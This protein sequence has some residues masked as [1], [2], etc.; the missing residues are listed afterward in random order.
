MEI[1]VSNCVVCAIAATLDGRLLFAGSSDGSLSVWDTSPSQGRRLQHVR[2]AHDDWIRCLAV[3][4]IG[5]GKEVLVS[6]SRDNTIRI[7][8]L[9]SPPRSARFAGA[10]TSASASTSASAPVTILKL[11]SILRGHTDWVRCLVPMEER[12]ASRRDRGRDSFHGNTNLRESEEEEGE[13]EGSSFLI[14]SA[15]DDCTIREWDLGEVARELRADKIILSKAAEKGQSCC[16]PSPVRV[17][18]ECQ[19]GFNVGDCPRSLLISP[20]GASFY[21]GIMDSTVRK[22]VRETG[23]VVQIL[24]GHTG[25]VTCMAYSPSHISS[26]SPQIYSQQQQDQLTSCLLYTGSDDHTIRQWCVE[27]GRCLRIFEGHSDWVRGLK[28]TTK[29]DVLYSGS[30]DC[31]LRVWETGTD[32][33]KSKDVCTS[34]SIASGI[35]RENAPILASDIT[36]AVRGRPLLQTS[37]STTSTALHANNMEARECVVR[38]S[39]SIS[40]H[41]EAVWDLEII[42]N[43]ILVS[44]SADG[45]VKYWCLGLPGIWKQDTH[46][47]YPK[48]FKEKVRLL[49]LIH[50]RCCMSEI[51]YLSQELLYK[52]IG[53]YATMEKRST[54]EGTEGHLLLQKR[55]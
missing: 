3:S 16:Q 6:G 31:T 10:P 27:S 12:L 29:G 24:K 23:Q 44:S 21:V 50:N 4:R 55:M 7:W 33:E 8:R 9:V 42:N 11:V 39:L 53:V 40:G 25:L 48:A 15:S 2:N 18:E 36:A 32:T 41:K 54:Q 49:L 20:D 45:R 19:R 37:T 28:V 46:Y 34:S 26:P 1:D 13:E 22:V 43:N 35:E 38:P 30:A 14:L 5:K 17:V 47:L 51:S 52:I